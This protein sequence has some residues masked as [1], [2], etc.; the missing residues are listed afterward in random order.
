MKYLKIRIKIYLYSI[1]QLKQEQRY[2]LIFLN[3]STKGKIMNEKCNSTVYQK[4]YN[5]KL[6]LKANE[7]NLLKSNASKNLKKWSDSSLSKKNSS[8]HVF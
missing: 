2:E 6:I 8:K 4:Y 1:I 7:I 3:V 5:W